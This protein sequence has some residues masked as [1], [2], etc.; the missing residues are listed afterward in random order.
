[1]DHD[2][3]PAPT[4]PIFASEVPR[5]AEQVDDHLPGFGEQ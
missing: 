1:M 4:I 5:F 3:P 2:T